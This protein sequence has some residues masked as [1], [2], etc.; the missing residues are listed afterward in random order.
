[1]TNKG[2]TP[3]VATSLLLL[4]SIAAV[5]SSAL[6]LGDTIDSVAS[7]VEETLGVQ[8][9]ERRAGLTIEYG[10]NGSD[11]NIWVDVSNSGEIT[12]ATEEDG[13]KLWNIYSDGSQLTWGYANGAPSG[14]SIDPGET[15]TIDTNQDYPSLGDSVEIQLNG[16]YGTSSS[17]VCSNNNGEQSC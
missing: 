8:D 1:M 15:I 13:D 7:G 5:S 9:N 3:V 11:G 16:Q 6:F 17:I 10:Y 12:L 2:V 14:N 4:I